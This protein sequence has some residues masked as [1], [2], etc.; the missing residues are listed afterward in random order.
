LSAIR[1]GAQASGAVGEQPRGSGKEHGFRRRRSGR[2][3]HQAAAVTDPHR[4]LD[5]T[6]M[7]PSCVWR[8]QLGADVHARIK[9]P[10]LATLEA[11]RGAAPPAPGKGWQSVQ[12]LHE[13]EAFRP[14]VAEIQVHAEEVLAYLQIGASALT[15]TGCWAN[16]NPPGAAH[17][18][19]DHPNNFLS[20]IYYLQ[21]AEGA[22]T[23]NFHDPRPQ[24]AVIRPPVRALTADN[25]DQ[26]VIRVE[27]GTMLMFPAWLRHSVDPNA[28]V[29]VRIS[30][31]FNLM[32]S[33]YAERLGKPLW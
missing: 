22:D 16:L 30:I 15:I 31:S 28:S 21:V 7:F 24:A 18:E 27:A 2:Q 33:A 25:A 29:G 14:L 32:F 1:R 5:V 3:T 20:G 26:V 9:A 8:R 17:R 12:T 4:R 23:V 6:R 19:H 13:L 10:A 11:M